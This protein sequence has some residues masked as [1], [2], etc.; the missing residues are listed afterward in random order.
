MA[1]AVAGL[2]TGID[3]DAD[4]VVVERGS[5][6]IAASVVVDENAVVDQCAN[7]MAVAADHAT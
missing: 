1:V 3:V 7:G 2:V 6:L 4:V 5:S